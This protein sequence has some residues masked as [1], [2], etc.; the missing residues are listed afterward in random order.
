[1]P[2][3]EP[4]LHITFLDSIQPKATAA[5]YTV[6]VEHTLTEEGRPVDGNGSDKLPTAVRKF[7]IRAARF[8]LDESSVHAF[9]PAEGASGAYGSAL[10]HIT[11]NRPFL[12][13]ERE[14]LATRADLGR[15]PWLALLVFGEGEIPDDPEATGQSTTRTVAELRRPGTG[16]LGPA[17]SDEGID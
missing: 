7:E 1:M 11:L 10:P 4:D 6:R 3:T 8:V 13:W 14:L 2:T 16:I 17:L 9:Y 12:P 5:V 15:P